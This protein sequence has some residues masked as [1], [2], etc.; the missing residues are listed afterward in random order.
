MWRRLHQQP[1]VTVTLRRAL[2]DRDCDLPLLLP[3]RC[4]R[5]LSR[6]FTPLSPCDLLVRSTV[7]QILH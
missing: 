2:D 6:F 3:S 5:V 7:N 4:K 1:Q